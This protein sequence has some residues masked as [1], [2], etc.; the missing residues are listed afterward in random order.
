MFDGVVLS[1]H[2]GRVLVFQLC[3]QGVYVR[4]F[5]YAVAGRV[6]IIHDF[7]VQVQEHGHPMRA[8]PSVDVEVE[9][10]ADFHM[11]LPHSLFDS[12]LAQLFPHAGPIFS[13]IEIGW[14]RSNVLEFVVC[15][16]VL[17]QHGC[18]LIARQPL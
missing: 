9:D 14:G 16:F 18:N 17:P 10:N 5:F 8:R 4:F 1:Q 2:H 7:L 15:P 12:E 11:P 13:V 6:E 3:E